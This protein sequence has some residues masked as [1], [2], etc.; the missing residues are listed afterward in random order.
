MATRAHR[1]SEPRSRGSSFQWNGRKRPSSKHGYQPPTT[2]RSSVHLRRVPKHLPSGRTSFCIP[3]SSTG[4]WV[5]RKDRPQRLYRSYVQA[6]RSDLPPAQLAATTLR[7]VPP[8][9]PAA[10]SAVRSWGCAD[11]AAALPPG[12]QPLLLHRVQPRIQPLGEPEDSLAHPH[13]REAIH[14]LRVPQVFPPLRSADP[15]F[16]HPHRREAVRLR[17]VWE[18]L[19]ELCWPQIPPALSQQTTTVDW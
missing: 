12:L 11:Q 10:L 17:A 3:S 2:L 8:E 16:P 14:L 13:R 15:A 1:Y 7:S 4:P 9:A 6:L 5:P 18:V 19:Q